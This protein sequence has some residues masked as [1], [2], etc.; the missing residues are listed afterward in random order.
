M[1]VSV[2]KTCLRAFEKLSWHNSSFR[3]KSM[4]ERGCCW[5]GV[6]ISGI[7]QYNWVNSVLN[8]N[9]AYKVLGFWFFGGC[10]GCFCGF[11]VFHWL[12][13]KISMTTHQGINILKILR[14]IP[15]KYTF[16]ECNIRHSI[17]FK[18]TVLPSPPERL[19]L[20]ISKS[21]ISITEIFLMIR[22]NKLQS[23]FSLNYEVQLNS[24]RR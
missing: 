22:N 10:L 1:Q 8:W 6:F 24:S 15:T 9:T 17:L 20:T 2:R 21:C 5:I 14:H 7:F 13:R 4:W 16:I 3:G 12:K 18:G 23:K 19:P 11:R